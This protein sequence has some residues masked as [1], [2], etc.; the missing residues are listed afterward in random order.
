M[1]LPPREKGS[2]PHNPLDLRCL[3]SQGLARKGEVCVVCAQ[4]RGETLLAERAG[5]QLPRELGS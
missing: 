5:V 2:S 4:A 1:N 3:A